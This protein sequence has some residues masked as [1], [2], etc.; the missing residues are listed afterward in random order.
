[1]I[2]I[3]KMN[4]SEVQNPQVTKSRIHIKKMNKSEVQNPQVMKSSYQTE[5]RKMTSY[6]ELLTRKFL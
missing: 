3:K 5:L 4:K 2:H 1:M 6:F